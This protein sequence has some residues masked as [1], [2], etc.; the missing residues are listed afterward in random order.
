MDRRSFLMSSVAVAA[1]LLPRPTRAFQTP[2][3]HEHASKRAFVERANVEWQ[4]EFQRARED[5]Q[6]RGI[7]A[8]LR[9]PQ[10]LVPFGDWDYY[11]IKGMGAVWAPNPGQP[12]RPVNVPVGFVT[13]LASVPS[14]AWSS[15]IRPEG[16]YAYAAIIHDY[17]YWTRERPRKEA[18]EIF[19]MA[20]VDSKVD[21]D[22]RQRIYT[23]VRRFGRNAWENNASL[24]ANG[25]R[26]ILRRFPEDFTISWEEWKRQPDVFAD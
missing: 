7:I 18:D 13:D 25:E 21:E 5:M 14:W 26:R 24:K 12:Y 10:Q 9:P 23:A 4:A 11:Y 20:M 16:R 22:L 3:D 8:A 1:T 17:L 2:P 6:R 19:L 15:G